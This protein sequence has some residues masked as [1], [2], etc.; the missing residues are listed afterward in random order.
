[1]I[2]VTLFTNFKF[3]K[4][5][6]NLI[7]TLDDIRNGKYAPA[8]NRIRTCMDQGDPETA[9]AL[10]KQLPAITISATYGKQRLKEY[11]TAY[12]PLVILDFDELNPADLPRHIGLIREACY[13]VACWISPRGRG[14]KIIAYPAVGIETVTGNHP[15]LYK[16]AKD[17]YERLLGVGADTSGGDAG[18]LC[19]LSYDP[20]LYLSPRFEP[21]LKGGGGYARRFAG[22]GSGGGEK[23]VASDCFRP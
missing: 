18:R 13:T 12:N 8:V 6:V 19:I 3:R 14:I 5:D 23:A 1:M 2:K 11:M 15:A 20:M 22:D 17:W 7:D 16:Q 10:K 21:W 9:D 4:G